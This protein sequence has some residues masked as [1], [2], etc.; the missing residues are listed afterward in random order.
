MVPHK[1]G[2]AAS[3]VSG[4]GLALCRPGISVQVTIAPPLERQKHIRESKRQ[5]SV[6][7]VQIRVNAGIACMRNAPRY[8]INGAR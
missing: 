6:M 2:L 8:V 5:G 1:A 3:V 7:G 4:P